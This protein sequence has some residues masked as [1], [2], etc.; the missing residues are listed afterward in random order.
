MLLTSGEWVHKWRLCQSWWGDHLLGFADLRVR[1]RK[2]QSDGLG[3]VG[4]EPH[5]LLQKNWC[6]TL[7]LVLHSWLGQGGKRDVE[8]RNLFSCS[9]SWP[10]EANWGGERGQ[11]VACFGWFGRFGR[12]ALLSGLRGC[13]LCAGS[14]C[15]KP[16]ACCRGWLKVEHTVQV[17]DGQVASLQ[18]GGKETKWLVVCSF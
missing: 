15:R 11:K 13:F 2:L 10:S 17:V 8:L 16:L 7:V 1:F 14:F 18:I 3:Q 4:I 9:N 5:S 12:L 6:E